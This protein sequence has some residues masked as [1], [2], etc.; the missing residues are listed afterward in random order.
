MVNMREEA[1][2]CKTVDEMAIGDRMAVSYTI[3]NDDL[4][5]FAE[6]SGDWNP[7]HFDDEYASRSMFRRRVAHGMISLAKFSGIFGMDLPGLGTLWETQ[8]VRF[9]GPVFLDTP[10]M[11]V[12][13][14]IEKDR[15]RV[16]IATWVEDGNGTHVLEGKAT[17]IPLSES[18]R[19]RLGANFGGQ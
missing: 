16:S 12:A 11:A 13:E 3:T 18:A 10:Y 8:E 5:K 19:R 1:R 14:V 2:A 7:L 15:R 17:V 4:R 6:I 9:V